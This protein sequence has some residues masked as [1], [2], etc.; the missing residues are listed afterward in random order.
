MMGVERCWY[1]EPGTA[2]VLCNNLGILLTQSVATAGFKVPQGSRRDM[3]RVIYRPR[4]RRTSLDS[5]ETKVSDFSIGTLLGASFAEEC[6]ILITTVPIA[7]L[8][9]GKGGWAFGS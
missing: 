9:R 6:D 4:L 1:G 7:T 8:R 5:P 3:C 2:V